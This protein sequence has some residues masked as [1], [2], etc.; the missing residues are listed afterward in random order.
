[1]TAVACSTER[2]PSRRVRGKPARLGQVLEGAAGT[3]R[4]I[5]TASGG[6][7]VSS[8][9]SPFSESHQ[10]TPRNS[11]PEGHADPRRDHRHG[12]RG[13][14]GR[15]VLGARAA[16]LRSDP[17]LIPGRVG[18]DPGGVRPNEGLPLLPVQS[19]HP[20][21]RAP[22]SPPME[23]G[24]Y[25]ASSA[26]SLWALVGA[27]GGM[28]FFSA[29][30]AIPWFGLF[31]VLTVV[32][33]L[34]EQSLSQ[35]AAL[36]PTPIVTAFFVLNIGGVSSRRI[37]SSS[38]RSARATPPSTGRSACSSTSCRGPSPNVSS[39]RQGSL[40]RATQT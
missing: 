4:V 23:P 12:A 13:R 18:G 22:V 37:C 25:A 40:P 17:V 30:A 33:G 36:I 35:H 7:A 32:S 14:V 8:S 31:V 38:T 26:V 10:M 20:D 34:A 11:R 6:S 16:R 9:V 28:F 15:N 3:G 27:L 29:V 2:S 1:M 19:G 24:G 39:A 21:H 5:S